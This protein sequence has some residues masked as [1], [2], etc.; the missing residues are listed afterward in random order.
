MFR[1]AIRALLVTTAL[2]AGTCAAH[3]RGKETYIDLES[4]WSYAVG[5]YS[6]SVKELDERE[7]KPLNAL[8]DLEK[9]IPGQEGILWLRREFEVPKSLKNKRL[10]VALGV[11]NPAD[12]TYLNGVF[13]G[14]GGVMP[15]RSSHFFSE[16][17][18]FRKY[19]I[20]DILIRKGVNVLYVKMYVNHEGLLEGERLVGTRDA[21][22]RKS[23]V[24]RFMREG[25]NALI[26]FVML[27]IGL[28]H[29]LI[30]VKR[31]K[32]RENLYY[33]MLSLFFSFYQ[34]NLF[35]AVTPFDI[36]HKVSYFAF[37]KFIWTCLYLAAFSFILFTNAYLGITLPKH[38]QYAIA[39]SFA[40]AIMAVL[41]MP[42][43]RIFVQYG[44]MLNA[45]VGIS[46]LGYCFS[47]IVIQA[48]KKN[49]LARIMLI[50]SVPLA[51][52]LLFDIVIHN[53]LRLVGYIY[54][55]GLGFPSY[56]IAIMFILA[57]RF[58]EYHNEVEELNITLDRKVVERTRQLQEA[59]E[60]LEEAYERMNR[61]MKMAASVQEQLFPLH[62]PRL[63]GWDIA[64]FF[65]PMAA[66]SGDFFDFYGR[67]DALSGF[68]LFDVS[69]HGVASGLLTM[70][71]KSML[72]KNYFEMQDE[73]L[74]AVLE[75]TN[76]DLVDEIG[77]LGYYLSGI[78]L[79]VRE[80]SDS[81]E[82]VNAAHP[83]VIIKRADGRVNPVVPR[84][85]DFKGNFIGLSSM[86]GGFNV[87]R[88]R[89]AAGDT[90]LAC[91][92]GL[93]ECYDNYG[94]QYEAERVIKVLSEVPRDATANDMLTYLL[95]DF[96][97]FAGRREDFRDDITVL[98]V[99][100]LA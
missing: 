71:A 41:V 22:D 77:D 63:Q 28:Y 43:Y 81:I 44:K 18:H 3:T 94:R 83:D 67:D 98:I 35:A 54:L 23:A 17:N 91:T 5:D 47:V 24:E 74:G 46:T 21:I 85:S 58:V 65:K 4:G 49:R 80:D 33:A 51:F 38:V 60:K 99:K 89:F 84:Q 32:D 26:S 16:W 82:Y 1:Y 61:D 10:S 93:L 42:E 97:S 88:F 45:I 13:I 40:V 31:P 56:L 25:S 79:R 7:F 9:L 72:R 55:S 92:D 53:I 75:S 76:D 86:K 78:L 36:P 6:D 62:P 11:I 14:K 48:V 87:V 37:Q 64:L 52:C 39:S 15:S 8:V 19:D 34:A 27:I 95:D 66:V 50:G 68:A 90:I 57:S 69:G 59:N 96:Y 29:L 100:R 73:R 70:I 20:P 2:I 30:F 12:E